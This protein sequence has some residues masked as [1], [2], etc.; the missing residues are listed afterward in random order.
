MTVGKQSSGTG[1]VGLVAA[2]LFF[3]TFLWPGGAWGASSGPVLPGAV[4]APVVKLITPHFGP[5]AGGTAVTIRG[6]N[7]GVHPVVRFG[8]AVA[9]TRPVKGGGLLAKSPAGSGVVDVTVTSAGGT[10]LTGSQDQFSYAPVVTSISPHAG[11]AAGG[12]AVTIRGSNFGVHPVVRFGSAVA[13][14][15][16]VK[17]GGLLAKSPAG[18]GVVDVTVTSAGG[19]SLTGSQDQFSYAPVVTSISPHAGPAAGGTAVTI[20]GSNFGVHPVVRFGSAV[21]TTRPVKGGGLLAKSPAGSGVVDVTVTSAGGTSLT[22]SQDQFSYAPVVTSISP[23]AGPAAGGTAVTIRGSNFGVH[24][25]VRFGSAVATTRPVKGGGLLAKSPAGSGVVDVTV[26]SAGGTSL[27]GSQDQFS[28]A[29]VVTSISPHAGPAAGGTAVTI[30]GAGLTGA[31]AVRFGAHAAASFSVISATEI[32]AV[33]PRG[34]GIAFVT[35]RTPDGLSPPGP[36]FSYLPSVTSLSPGFGPPSGGTQVTITGVGFSAATAV[37]FGASPAAG[38]TIDSDTRITANSPPGSGAV[39]VTVISAEGPSPTSAADQFA[40]QVPAPAVTGVAPPNGSSAGGT[41]VIITGSGFTGATAVD[42]GTT[43]A[44][45]F[46]VNSDTQITA[47]APGRP[48]GTVDVTVTTTGGTS[49]NSAADL[50]AYEI[51]SPTVTSLNPTNGPTAGGTPVTITGSGFTGATAVMFG[52]ASASS[53]TVH[54]D[55]QISAISPGGTAGTIDVVITTPAGSS[56]TGTDDQFTYQ[57][58]GIPQITGVNPTE[59]NDAGGEAVTVTGSGFTGATEVRLD[60][61]INNQPFDLPATSF[62][63]IDDN[64]IT[65]VTP[66]AQTCAIEATDFRVITSAGISPITPADVAFFNC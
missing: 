30:T 21:A 54:S 8:S 48:A 50:F 25:V 45:S 4:P 60:R 29:P 56:P 42:F 3:F 9:T 33:S 65:V 44:A 20:R 41:Q 6:S 62:T 36:G 16:P 52:A 46:T 37:D 38:F 5:A 13:T 10:S 22:G 32:D 59:F 1:R 35:V 51:P 43:P 19:T 15:R 63:V 28:Y 7:F 34:V 31:T 49:L 58:A 18:S 57:K 55:T 12:T 64:T 27:T 40:Y 47:T 14:T 61:T 24:P 2:A 66:A 53:F 23:H 39:D 11:P 17:G 26:T